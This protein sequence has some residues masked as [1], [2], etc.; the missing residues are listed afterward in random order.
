[1]HNM[2]AFSNCAKV[3]AEYFEGVSATRTTIAINALPTPIAVELKV[4]QYRLST[5]LPNLAIFTVYNRLSPF[6]SCMNS[7]MIVRFIIAS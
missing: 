5:A 7:S 4:A 2:L 6:L 1:M 3:Y